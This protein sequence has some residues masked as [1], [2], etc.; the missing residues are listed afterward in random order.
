MRLGVSCYSTA[1][2]PNELAHF[3]QFLQEKLPPPPEQILGNFMRSGSPLQLMQCWT[4][5]KSHLRFPK[6]NQSRNEDLWT[7]GGYNRLEG[8]IKKCSF[9]QETSL[10][11]RH[12]ESS[13]YSRKCK[14]T[15]YGSMDWLR[16]GSMCSCKCRCATSHKNTSLG[17]K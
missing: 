12:M 10:K 14:E 7:A 11:S 8:G 6:F 13:R 17:T 15:K 1:L 5:Y 9:H 4:A 3:V 16:I 2:L